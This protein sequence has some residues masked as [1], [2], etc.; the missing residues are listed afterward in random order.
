MAVNQS[1]GRRGALAAGLTVLAVLA[2]VYWV[3]RWDP[4]AGRPPGPRFARHPDASLKLVLTPVG[5]ATHDRIGVR[6]EAVNDGK[7]PLAF[8][9][10]FAAP[11][12]WRLRVND[13]DDVELWYPT[14]REHWLLSGLEGGPG[15]WSR[16]RFVTIKPGDRLTKEVVLTE[17]HRQIGYRLQQIR[18][19]QGNVHPGEVPMGTE[20][21][22]R[23][24]VP[25]LA[26][27]GAVDTLRVRLDYNEPDD[28]LRTAFQSLFRFE[29]EDVGLW[30]G[31]CRSNELD[32]RLAR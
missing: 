22:A 17:P 26:P 7:V 6:V 23:L 11:L 29:P 25:K 19:P 12:T 30:A 9:P 4:A 18:D 1:P 5:E 31:T 3:W 10:E 32:F 16:S 21:L 20:C 27:Q 8:D 15:S 14:Q 13:R 2:G 24:V 28:R